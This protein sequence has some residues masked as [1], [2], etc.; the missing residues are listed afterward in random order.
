VFGFLGNNGAG[1]TTTIRIV[2]GLIRPSRGIFRVFGYTC[3][4]QITQAKR[5]IGGLVDVPSFYE[6][7]TG[8]DNLEIFS[9]F[10]GF[11]PR[12]SEVE[13]TAELVGIRD[14]MHNQ[15]RIYS[16]GQKRRLGIAQALLP[17]PRL[18]VLDEPTAGLDP[19]GVKSI[20]ELI[21][22]LN[23]QLN[24]TVV[25]SSH[26]LGEVQ[27]T[28]NRVS[29]IHRGSILKTARVEEL[30]FEASYQFKV[31][32]P[33]LAESF[34]REKN[35]SFRT[36]NGYYL[37]PVS[38]REVP[39]LVREMSLRNIGIYELSPCQVTLEEVFLQTVKEN[40]Q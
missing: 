33:Q 25:L 36:R 2:F 14:I 17:R 8:R 22:E 28:C 32:P 29:I 24:I 37:L 30:L 40:K 4:R 15:V 20:R 1:K 31:S 18:V 21:T 11:T 39:E 13:E 9:S 19:E 34:F 12:R 6:T 35:I 23:R 38:S 3:P 5:V 16:N 27:K 26:V 10:A 7:L